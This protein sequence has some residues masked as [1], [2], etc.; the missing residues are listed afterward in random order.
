VQPAHWLRWPRIESEWFLAHY[1]D[2]CNVQA[3]TA[4]AILYLASLLLYG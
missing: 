2:S 4:A 3:W 1:F